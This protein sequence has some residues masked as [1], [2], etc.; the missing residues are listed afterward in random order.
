M[1]PPG[2]GP[3]AEF[4][5]RIDPTPDLCRSLRSGSAFFPRFVVPPRRRSVLFSNLKSCPFWPPPQSV[6]I[7]LFRQIPAAFCL[8]LCSDRVKACQPLCDACHAHQE[9]VHHA[10]TGGPHQR[11]REVGF[12]A[13]A[14]EYVRELIRRDIRQEEEHERIVAAVEARLLAAFESQEE[15]EETEPG[16]PIP[17]M[18]KDLRNRIKDRMRGGAAGRKR[19]AG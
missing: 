3:A 14:S 5:G 11:G 16:D 2:L 10:V 9:R 15:P 12:Y 8:F 6:G 18:L 19:H 4:Y 13:S 1:G 7:S 17:A